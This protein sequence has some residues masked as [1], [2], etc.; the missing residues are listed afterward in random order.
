MSTPADAAGSG[1]LLRLAIAI[2]A[3]DV[4]LG[5]LTAIDF[6][7][8]GLLWINLFWIVS[9]GGAWTLSLY[10]FPTGVGTQRKVRFALSA[11]LGT[12][13]LGQLVWSAQVMVDWAV[14]PGPSDAL[15][16]FAPLPAIW[17]M[18]VWIRSRASVTSF[19]TASLDSL[20]V[21]MAIVVGTLAIFDTKADGLEA[22]TLLL[23]PVL[24]LSP[25]G[26]IL[27]T[28]LAISER[29][30]LK[31]VWMVLL[32]ASVLG[33]SFVVWTAQALSGEIPV[34]EAVDY[35]FGVGLLLVGFGAATWSD[36][37][38][39]DR[40]Q[41]RLL[42]NL[43]E[44][45]P[46][47]A[48][49]VATSV[50]L[51]SQSL[52]S[53]AT[54]IWLAVLAMLL[55]NGVRQILLIRSQRRSQRSLRELAAV[56][57]NTEERER[58]KI[59]TYLHDQVSQSIAVLSLKIGALRSAARAEDAAILIDEIDQLLSQ[60]A[61]DARSTTFDLS[62]P[63]LYELGLA[64]AITRL[65]SRLSKKFSVEIT[66]FD[67]GLDKPFNDDLG[68]LLY[69]FVRELLMNVVKHAQATEI[70]VQISREDETAII[71]VEDNGHGF[72]STAL[73]EGNA[74]GFGLYSISERTRA[75]G[76]EFAIQ[77]AL[78]EGTRACIRVPIKA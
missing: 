32:G 65:A 20:T 34:G 37:S 49:V 57:S 36:D 2:I 66:V 4:V 7:N 43:S 55:I 23:Y 41:R 19:M 64:K 14:V 76:G 25:V 52:Q 67:D 48:I 30:R 24:Y 29:P 39:I 9:A 50:A 71:M 11:G 47:A 70:S 46:L 73:V 12:Y 28:V 15:F 1:R 6:R 40:R 51:K 62:P 61:D 58:R 5:L 35:L 42:G 53:I 59:A 63:S 78:G 56:L 3:F 26:A 16:L 38:V 31:G 60:T 22:V 68:P 69:R 13:F 44:I 33:G 54:P 74:S 75:I 18:L 17:G 77:S 10:R 27:V 8:S 45:L 72:D 21:L